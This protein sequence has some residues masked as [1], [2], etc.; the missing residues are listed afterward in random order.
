MC[1]SK[2]EWEL[3]TQHVLSWIRLRGMSCYNHMYTCKPEQKFPLYPHMQF[4][5]VSLH[6]MN[7]GHIRN[8]V[9]CVY[10]SWIHE[11]TGFWYKNHV[12]KQIHIHPCQKNLVTFT[13]NSTYTCILLKSSTHAAR[14]HVTLY[15]WSRINCT[16]I[17]WRDFYSRWHNLCTQK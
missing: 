17:K 7:Y 16:D 9:H 2:A 11:H 1:P 8:L 12:N 5:S 15:I 13:L 14:V 4:C 3:Y 10:T 6:H